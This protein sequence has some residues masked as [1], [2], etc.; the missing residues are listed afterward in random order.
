LPT[1]GHASSWINNCDDLR[2]SRPV[3]LLERIYAGLRREELLWLTPDD[4]D[5][6]A[7]SFGLIRVRAKTIDDAF[8]QPKTKVNRAVPISSSLRLYLDKWKLKGGKGTWLFPNSAGG[9][10]D[11]DNF[12]SDLRAHNEAKGLHWT[13]LDYRHTFGS[14][15][16]MK[17]ESLYKISKLMGNSPEIC[18]RHYAAL[19]P[20]EMGDAVEFGAIKARVNSPEI[21]KSVPA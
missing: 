10:Y 18:R 21:A 5:W 15:L 17:G 13:C 9:R 14:Q 4:I 8:W 7:G 6:S 16:A 2:R 19:I 11:P 12:S 3:G 20:E 1:D